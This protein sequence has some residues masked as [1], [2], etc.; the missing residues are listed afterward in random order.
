MHGETHSS[1]IRGE[2]LAERESQIWTNPSSDDETR[3]SLPRNNAELT[4]LV[5]PL[6]IC[7]EGLEVRQSHKRNVPSP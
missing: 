6:N 2:Q 5:W 7:T 3:R 4:A 1:E